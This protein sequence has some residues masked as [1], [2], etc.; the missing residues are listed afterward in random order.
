M[1][2]SDR[3]AEFDGNRLSLKFLPWDTKFFRRPSYL[4]DIADSVFDFSTGSSDNWG[5]HL[6]NSFITVKLNEDANSKKML[7]KLQS[8]GFR[9]IGTELVLQNLWESKAT[10]S[11][12]EETYPGVKFI[13]IEKN[14]N[15]P[16]KNLGSL[17]EYSRFHLE[18]NIHND[19]ADEFWS[20]YLQSIQL[21]GNKKMF[22]ATYLGEIAGIIFVQQTL[23]KATLFFVAILEKYR[24][25][26]I[27]SKLIAYS[28]RM[29]NSENIVTEVYA[30]NVRALNFYLRNG[31][32]K[33]TCSRIVLHRWS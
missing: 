25:L 32:R 16:Y 7:D 4:L 31:F 2:C 3:I 8:F 18:Q 20:D 26:N 6:D 33:V 14:E 21:D 15:L 28:I 30:G 22:A 10:I 13:E 1:E 23:A 11:E 5:Y 24:C 17:F 19:W 9:Y 12:Q 27:G 29:L